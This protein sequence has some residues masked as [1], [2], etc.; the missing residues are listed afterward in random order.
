MKRIFIVTL[1][2]VGSLFGSVVMPKSWTVVVSFTKSIEDANLF[3]QKNIQDNQKR[4][5]IFET[6]T[7]YQVTYGSFSTHAQ[8]ISFYKGFTQNIIGFK[9]Y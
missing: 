2:L 9:P 4:I 3:L 6:P 8:A 1:I 5:F 7:G